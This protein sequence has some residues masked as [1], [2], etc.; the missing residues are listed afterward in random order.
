ME[1][2]GTEG[3]KTPGCRSRAGL[4]RPRAA[5]SG[6]PMSLGVTALPRGH[7]SARAGASGNQ[8]QIQR[9]CREHRGVGREGAHRTGWGGTQLQG[10]PVTK[11]SLSPPGDLEGPYP[12]QICPKDLLQLRAPAP[13]APRP[14]SSSPLPASSCHQA[15]G[16]T[17]PLRT[18]HPPMGC[19]HGSDLPG[20]QWSHPRWQFLS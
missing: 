16:P 9:A 2:V 4:P 6:K 18:P 1:R 5:S 13:P 8:L 17:R 19:G 15:R 10:C 3:P 12:T 11:Q 14:L 20:R 7:G